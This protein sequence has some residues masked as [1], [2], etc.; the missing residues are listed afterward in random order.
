M[1]ACVQLCVSCHPALSCHLCSPCV[2][3]APQP[4][5]PGVWIMRQ[6]PAAIAIDAL[7]PE[8]AQGLAM[9][10]EESVYEEAC[11]HVLCVTINLSGGCWCLVCV[12]VCTHLLSPPANICVC[13]CARFCNFHP[14]I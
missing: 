7:P 2:E 6:S 4:P 13:M 10:T 8:S 14:Q 12:Y 1:C 9:H 11:I 3:G 5:A